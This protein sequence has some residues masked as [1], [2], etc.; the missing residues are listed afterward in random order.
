MGKGLLVSSAL[1][2]VAAAPAGADS[3]NQFGFH[4]PG[5]AVG[6]PD[7]KFEAVS[8]D[9]AHVF[10]STPEAI[11]G[12]GDTDNAVDIYESVGGQVILRSLGQN[13]TG[14]TNGSPVSFSDISADGTKIAFTTNEQ[15]VQL[16]GANTGD[17]DN[18]RDVY[19]KN[20]VNGNVRH[21]SRGAGDLADDP[22]FPAT[23]EAMTD[24]GSRLFY[25]TLESHEAGDTDGA[26]DIY[27]S[28]PQNFIT[29][30]YTTF[31]NGAQGVTFNATNEG[32]AADKLV[33]STRERI[34]IQDAVDSNRDVFRVTNA[35]GTDVENVSQ[36][37]QPDEAVDNDFEGATPS[38]EDIA[39]SSEETIFASEDSDG[40]AKDIWVWPGFSGVGTQRSGPAAST[41]TS[42]FRDISD[43][44]ETVFLQTAGSWAGA[45]D[46][47]G[48]SDI[49]ADSGGA[50]TL[51]SRTT[52]ANDVV[53]G[54]SSGDGTRVWFRT[55]TSLAASDGDG[56]DDIY[57][58]ATAAPSAPA[59]VSVGTNGGGTSNFEHASAD[60]TRVTFSTPD[61]VTADDPDTTSDLHQRAGGLTYRVSRGPQELG[62]GHALLPGGGMT[63]DG[64]QAVFLTTEKMFASDTDNAVDLFSATARAGSG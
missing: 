44:G 14:N 10:F 1:L 41:A 18:A 50:P 7:L 28:Q 38:L 29:T 36:S 42:T 19:W 64:L 17:E 21:V 4:T 56:A 22:A 57:E 9:G 55:G 61:K 47:D 62:T 5:T 51:I 40:G 3:F 59:H 43:D 26:R 63:P 52:P 20:F 60:G 12:T 35:S 30:G 13:G 6:I 39:F 23:F 8:D 25:S 46:L 53:Y 37:S 48:F 15:L 49:Y 24:D 27:R 2:L 32:G 11:P 33:F 34:G 45:D 31:T 16:D 54:D 58:A